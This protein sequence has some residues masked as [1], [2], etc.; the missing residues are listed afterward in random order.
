VERCLH[1][2]GLFSC[3]EELPGEPSS[4]KNGARMREMWPATSGSHGGRFEFGLR[5]SDIP[6]VAEHTTSKLYSSCQA[7][8]EESRF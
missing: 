3:H 1:P 5:L 6:Y 2:L 8:R 4:T 7:E